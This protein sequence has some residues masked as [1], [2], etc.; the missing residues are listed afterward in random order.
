MYELT[1]EQCSKLEE[2]LT[3]IDSLQLTGLNNFTLAANAG[4]RLQYLLQELKK[5][6]IVVDN[7]IQPPKREVK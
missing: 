3:Q 4:V 5:Q 7:K 1:V 6:E 2:A